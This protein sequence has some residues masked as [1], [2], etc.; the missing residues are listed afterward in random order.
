MRTNFQQRFRH[1]RL[2]TSLYVVSLVVLIVCVISSWFVGS[3]ASI[4]FSPLFAVRTWFMGSSATIP[5]FF[6][7]HYSLVTEIQS[8]KDTLAQSASLTDR[9]RVLE[10]ENMLLR[11]L[12]RKGKEE[13]IVADVVMR[14]SDTPYDTL[15]IHRGS[16]DGIVEGALVYAGE[17]VVG[18]TARVFPEST[19][20][21]LFSAPGILSPVYVYGPNVFAHAEGMG[22][23][24]VRVRLP[25]GIVFHEGDMVTVP[26]F[27]SGI[28]GH[29][30]YSESSPSEPDQFAFVTVEPALS[31]V[32][33]VAVDPFPMPQISYEDALVVVKHT[34]MTNP[35]LSSLQELNSTLPF[36]TTTESELATSTSSSTP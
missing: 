28:Y 3:I 24:V 32:R 17:T 30:A 19:L 29:I 15:L 18:M 23:G 4:V 14:P 25:Q 13:R 35:L 26:M 34:T 22:G 6:R 21:V 5:T 1:S 33:F 10:S 2:R 20:V 8:L 36:A 31:E 27:G 7:T 12:T 16:D 9:V 11:G